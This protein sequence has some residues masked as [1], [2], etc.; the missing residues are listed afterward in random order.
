MAKITSKQLVDKLTKGFDSIQ[1]A[2]RGS[3]KSSI[4]KK[5][6]DTIGK[7][8]TPVKGGSRRLAGY[9][10][11]YKETI[12]NSQAKGTDGRVHRNK[13][14]RPVNL[15]VS[16][17]MLKSQKVT[18]TPKGVNI[19]Y[20]Q[21]VDGKNI[22]AQHNDGD[23][24]RGLPERRILPNRRGEEFSKEVQQHVERIANIS[25]KKAIRK[26]K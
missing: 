14:Q 17:D 2:F 16:G 22:A 4:G 9:S 20:T 11:S 21:K 13:R 5:I 12:K 6:N 23:P 26:L 15:T 7:G 24:G 18:L 3:L 19:T 1:K 8:R 10:D 25:V